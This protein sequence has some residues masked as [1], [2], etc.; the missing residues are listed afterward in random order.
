M[1]PP[2][3]LTDGIK[4]RLQSPT[5]TA[6]QGNG[7]MCSYHDLAAAGSVQAGTR[8]H[9]VHYNLYK[10]TADAAGIL[11][12]VNLQGCAKA[13]PGISHGQSAPCQ[14]LMGA[15]TTLVLNGGYGPSGTSLAADAGIP[16]L[17]TAVR[18]VVISKHICSVTQWRF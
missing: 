15:C 11:H 4:L 18:Y 6:P 16:I 12:H 8:Y 3:P 17:G 2:T 13:V 10:G 1:P 14:L 9:I 7:Y 5:G